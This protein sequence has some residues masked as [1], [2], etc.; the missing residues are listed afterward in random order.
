MNNLKLSNWVNFDWNPNT[1]E[2]KNS[3]NSLNIQFLDLIDLLTPIQ[4]SIKNN[5]AIERWRVD[6]SKIVEINKIHWNN[7]NIKLMDKTALDYHISTNDN[8]KWYIDCFTI[9]GALVYVYDSS[10]ET[11]QIFKN[12]SRWVRRTISHN[13]QQFSLIWIDTNVSRRNDTVSPT[14]SLQHEL[15]H[16]LNVT[17][18]DQLIM[19]NKNINFKSANRYEEVP[20]WFRS[21]S[22]FVWKNDT[23]IITKLFWRQI[24]LLW[25]HP[26]KKTVDYENYENQL[27]YFDELS[28][29]WWQAKSNVF[30]PKNQ[31]YNNVKLWNHNHYDLIWESPKDI[32]DLKTL[33][34]DYL[35]PWIYLFELKKNIEKAIIEEQQIKSSWGVEESMK[36]A[37]IDELNWKI[38][39]IDYLI[40]II[41]QTLWVSRT[42]NQ[43]LDLMRNVWN[44]RIL[45]N[46]SESYLNY[47]MAWWKNLNSL[48]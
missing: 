2:E 4:L 30:W 5:I 9:L 35:M 48:L 1:N 18:W 29:S 19:S 46:V 10:I 39:N 12:E 27:Y 11:P 14:I 32:E 15:Q 47:M 24:N 40:S 31:F 33:F 6:R 23:E 37:K 16:H 22:E 7:E 34:Q 3:V 43:A 38:A 45:P 25:D 41:T 28:A 44:T 36:K 13:W 17:L 21:K 26:A 42:V 8:N 20:N